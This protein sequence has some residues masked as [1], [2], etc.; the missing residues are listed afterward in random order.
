M[1]SID[2]IPWTDQWLAGQ[3]DNRCGLEGLITSGV[4]CKFYYRGCGKHAFLPL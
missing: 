4:V 1:F 3:G 2:C